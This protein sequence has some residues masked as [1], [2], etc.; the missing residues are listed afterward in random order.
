V[1]TARP[2]RFGLLTKGA[3]TRAGWLDLLARV[4]DSGFDSMLV[5]VHSTAQFSPVAALAD[6]AARTPLRIGTLVMNN[7]LQHPALLARDAVTLAVLSDGRF[8]L[9]I[10][11]GWMERDYRHLGIPLDP[12]RD[13]VTRLAE[14]IEIMRRYWNGTEVTVHGEH[15]HVD[16]LPGMAGPRVPL[17]VGAGGRRMLALA[18]RTAEIVSIA[19]DFSAGSTPH[20]VALDASLDSTERKVRILRGHLGDRAVEVE[21]NVLVVRVGV[22]SEARAHLDRYTSE[23]GVDLETARTTPENL[24]AAT[25]GELVDTL[26]ERRARTGISYYVF[27]EPNL[28]QVSTV[29]GRLAGAA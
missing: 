1:S 22:G 24:L 8:D 4:T 19:R 3:A 20:E 14:A 17:L 23:T 28:D 13:R 10:G 16:G 26:L 27:R 12:G 18:A 15:Y 5:P 2:F 11:A 25:E 29:V 6:A 7:D 9:G 21:L